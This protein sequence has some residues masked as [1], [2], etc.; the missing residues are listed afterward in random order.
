MPLGSAVVQ[1]M[2]PNRR[3]RSS[4]AFRDDIRARSLISLKRVLYAI[5]NLR[6]FDSTLDLMI[7]D[8]FTDTYS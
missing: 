8:N 7:H 5:V 6:T 3:S 1:I 4:I 2:T